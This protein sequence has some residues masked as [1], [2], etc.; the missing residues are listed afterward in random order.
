MAF[1]L[2]GLLCTILSVILFYKKSEKKSLILLG[3]LLAIT[4]V[5]RHNG[6]LFTL[7][8]L[9]ALYFIIEKKRWI[10]LTI[11][12]A[13]VLFIIKIPLYKTLNVEKPDERIVETVGVPISVICSVAKETPELMD[14]ELKDF[15]DSIGGRE[16]FDEY[17]LDRGFNSI[18]WNGVNKTAIEEA[19]YFKV[20]RCF[21]KAFHCSPMQATKGFIALTELVYGYENGMSGN[22]DYFYI[23]DNKYDIGY[24]VFRNEI[25]S[26]ILI[27]YSSLVNN[28]FLKYFRTHGVLLLILIMVMLTKFEPNNKKTWVKTLLMLP[29]L[30]Y[31]FGTML[32][33]SGPDARFFLI[34]FLLAPLLIVFAMKD[35][36][37]AYDEN[38]DMS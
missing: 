12:F 19:G 14:E 13:L 36:K 27:D 17:C 33:L 16:V 3:I 6:L 34:T 11:I 4:T 23:A 8:L 21:V 35:D 37:E 31:D 28:T 38:S 9:L 24:S 10:I 2:G 5:F 18:K 26:K 7:P 30:I 20:F 22:I 29:I 25:L 15:V 1:G 32:L